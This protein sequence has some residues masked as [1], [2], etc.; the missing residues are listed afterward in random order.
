MHESR[1]S[2]I[3][4]SYDVII[5]LK[6]DPQYLTV[7]ILSQNNPTHTTPSNFLN[8]NH[9]FE[10]NDLNTYF[11]QFCR[12]VCLPNDQCQIHMEN[13]NM[14]VYANQ[15]KKLHTHLFKRKKKVFLK[16]RPKQ[17]WGMDVKIF[18]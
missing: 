15:F 14:C 10:L 11:S 18:L 6:K 7:Q 17:I 12:P 16:L 5:N 13:I 4:I 8:C 1:I 9:Y 2:R 3:I